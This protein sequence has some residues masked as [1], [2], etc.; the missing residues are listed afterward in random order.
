M[1]APVRDTEVSVVLV[2]SADEPVERATLDAVLRARWPAGRREIVVVDRDPGGGQRPWDSDVHGESRVVVVRADAT[3]GYA[4]ARNA[5]AAAADG[6]F[7]A[8]L[9]AG[10]LPD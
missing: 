9:G 2:H 3:D 4:A 1:N 6:S 5:G 7:V 8:F 10:A